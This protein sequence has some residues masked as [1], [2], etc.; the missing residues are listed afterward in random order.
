MF[1]SIFYGVFDIPSGVLTYANAG[2]NP[3]YLLRSD[4]TVEEL[5]MTGDVAVAVRADISY[6][7]KSVDLGPGDTVFCYTDGLTEAKNASMEEFSEINLAAA[8]GDC[9]QV[10]VEGIGVLSNPVKLEK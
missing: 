6:R 8:L 4:R 9:D 10:E 3:P 1:V 5:E 2:H 7:E